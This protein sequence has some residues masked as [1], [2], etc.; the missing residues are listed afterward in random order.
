MEEEGQGAK[1]W[2]Q[3]VPTPLNRWILHQQYNLIQQLLCVGRTTVPVFNSG[4]NA[5]RFVQVI[6]VIVL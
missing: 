1:N 6:C 5:T 2:S 4:E 3:V